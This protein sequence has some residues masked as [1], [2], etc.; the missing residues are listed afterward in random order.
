M[1]LVVVV[2]VAEVVSCPAACNLKQHIRLR[3]R[4]YAPLSM[5]GGNIFMSKVK[6]TRLIEMA[7]EV[8]GLA[9]WSAG[10]QGQENKF[11]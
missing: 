1:M 10:M 6:T 9:G 5:L 7:K 2:A 11:T 3:A 8:R 4:L